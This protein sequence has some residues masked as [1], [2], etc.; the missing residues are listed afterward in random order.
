LR[1]LDLQN[2]FNGIDTRK[3]VLG[4]GVG[5]A[6]TMVPEDLLFFSHLSSSLSFARD[7]MQARVFSGVLFSGLT[8]AV[9]GSPNDCC[10]F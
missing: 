6:Y 1:L 9:S 2:I 7:R 3:K 10:L 8:L 5:I 4:F